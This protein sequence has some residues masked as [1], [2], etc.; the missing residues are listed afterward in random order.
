MSSTINLSFRHQAEGIND[1][2]NAT[3]TKRNGVL[4]FKSI[5]LSAEDGTLDDAKASEQEA[6]RQLITNRAGAVDFLKSR[7]IFTLDRFVAR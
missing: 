6:I 2:V 5:L 1:L 4:D 3:I 7:N